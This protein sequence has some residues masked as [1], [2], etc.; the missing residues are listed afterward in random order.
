[1]ISKTF[2]RIHKYPSS[3][4]T[5]IHITEAADAQKALRLLLQT[6]KENMIKINFSHKLIIE[7]KM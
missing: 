3:D 2:Y 5:Y 7:R 6:L 4:Y 1:M